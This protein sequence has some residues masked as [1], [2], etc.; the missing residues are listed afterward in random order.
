MMA[1]SAQAITPA[2]QRTEAA[3]SRLPAAA[4]AQQAEANANAARREH[5]G[6]NRERARQGTLRIEQ[7][8]RRG[9]RHSTLRGTARRQHALARV[10]LHETRERTEGSDRAP[11]QG[12]GGTLLGRGGK[13]KQ[14]QH[15]LG[16]TISWVW[17][18]ANGWCGNGSSMT[19]LGDAS[20]ARWS[21]CP[22]CQTNQRVDYSWLYP[23]SWV[24]MGTWGTVGA[25]YWWGCFGYSSIAATLRIAANGYFDGGY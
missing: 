5:E 12:A 21:C 2:V 4:N 13:P 25:S 18:R 24:H 19:W 22:Y 9:A 7:E 1:G 8:P 6:G 20:F 16:S 17:V 3:A 10:D 14:L 11:C 23:W 15:G